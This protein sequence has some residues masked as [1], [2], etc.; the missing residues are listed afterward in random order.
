MPRR[1]KGRARLDK[2]KGGKGINQLVQLVA[3]GT[4]TT[5]TNARTPAPKAG[6][7][8][9]GEIYSRQRGEVES[10]QAPQD[11]AR[12]EG[13]LVRF[14]AKKHEIKR[15]TKQKVSICPYDEAAQTPDG[16]AGIL[17]GFGLLSFKAEVMGPCAHDAAVPADVPEGEPSLE[18][19]AARTRPQW[20]QAP[21]GEMR[22]AHPHQEGEEETIGG[23]FASP[24]A[25]PAD[26]MTG[27]ETAED[28]M[29]EYNTTENGMTRYET[30]VGVMPQEDGAS[31]T[32]L[33]EDKPARTPA[34]ARRAEDGW[35]GA[36]APP[37][38]PNAAAERTLRTPPGNE[39]P[40]GTQTAPTAG[41][42]SAHADARASEADM[43][44]NALHIV[45][46][47]FKHKTEQKRSI[48]LRLRPEF[49]GEVSID[50]V[51]EDDGLRAQLR[52]RSL[53]VKEA[54]EGQ[55][56]TLHEALKEKGVQVSQIEVSCDAFAFTDQAQSGDHGPT[57]RRGR[58]TVRARRRGRRRKPG[59]SAWTPR[60]IRI[61]RS[62]TVPSNLRHERKRADADL[63]N[64]RIDTSSG[65]SQA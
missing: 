59:A 7:S 29:T 43:A 2:D 15:A 39:Q 9:F 48:T 64:K 50:I 44:H 47:I 33:R 45:E 14:A 8:P 19:D 40:Q 36:G 55:L 53:A 58:A 52:T 41:S 35:E 37:A 60:A 21:P 18:L 30:A 62:K 27:N 4:R 25:A 13:K 22:R 28:G 56:G 16:D 61:L 38:H 17:E 63:R 34:Q 42:E 12:D 6:D 10:P 65:P 32:D 57:G 11:S 31:P 24:A 54:M 3:G 23:S 49:L 46:S 5:A 20:A 1:C 26:E 51:E